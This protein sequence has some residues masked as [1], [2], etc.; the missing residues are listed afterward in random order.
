MISAVYIR[1][2][3]DTIDEANDAL[4]KES[5][6]VTVW[7]GTTKGIIPKSSIA[8]VAEECEEDTSVNLSFTST[9][10]IDGNIKMTDDGHLFVKNVYTEEECKEWVKEIE[11]EE[12]CVCYEKTDFVTNCGHQFCTG[13]IMR[14]YHEN[15][16]TCPYCK[17]TLLLDQCTINL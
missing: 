7:M 2:P 5:N 16:D 3:F 13:C 11:S 8:I 4:A 17:Q 1:G 9:P 14:W 6:P 12:C 15:S 10:K